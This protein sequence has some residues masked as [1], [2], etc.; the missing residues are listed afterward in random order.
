MDN[1]ET[2]LVL[3]EVLSER[4]HQVERWG[5]GKDDTVNTPHMW[6][7]WI[8]LYG[9]KWTEGEFELNEEI[10]DKF[11]ECMIKVA[12]IATAAAESI[13]RQRAENG[14]TFYE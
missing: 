11:R 9:T 3:T 12:A 1:T 7:T 5:N 10:T 4:K 6:L 14:S 2:S 13:D 8:Q